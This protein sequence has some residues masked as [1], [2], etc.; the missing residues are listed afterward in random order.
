M[1]KDVTKLSLQSIITDFSKDLEPTP[2]LKAE[3]RVVISEL[4]RRMTTLEGKYDMQEF[5]EGKIKHHY[6]TGVYGREL[7]IPEGQVIV[8]KI[9]RGKTFNII[10]EGMVS[11]I[12]EMGYHT[13]SAPYVFVSDP[14]T[15][16]V[17]ISHMDSIWVTAHGSDKTDLQDIEEEIIAKDFSELNRIEEEL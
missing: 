6:A 11:V 10:T 2:E 16:R 12:S 4:E 8:S 15:K 1:T 14:F 3:R 9:H 5:N 17:V 13:Y 7:F